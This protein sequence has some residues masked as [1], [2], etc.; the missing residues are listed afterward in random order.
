MCF[1]CVERA[2]V[3]LRIKHRGSEHGDVACCI[4][5]TCESEGHRKTKHFREVIY[6]EGKWATGTEEVQADEAAAEGDAIALKTD[7]E[8]TLEGVFELEEKIFRVIDPEDLHPLSEGFLDGIDVERISNAVADEGDATAEVRQ[9]TAEQVR[10]A[11]VEGAKQSG[12]RGAAEFLEVL[13]LVGLMEIETGADA[14]AEAEALDEALGERSEVLM[15]IGA[16]GGMTPQLLE[17]LRRGSAAVAHEGDRQG[18]AEV[19]GGAVAGS[20]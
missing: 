19:D 16:A 13:S 1:R 15:E 12:L 3:V 17:I 11:Y 8:A 5:L 9:H 14:T 7:G 2:G 18:G 10:L 20:G 6:G 4:G